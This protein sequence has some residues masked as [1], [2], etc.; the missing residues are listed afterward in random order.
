LL[1]GRTYRI[2]AHVPGEQVVSYRDEDE[3]EEWREE[4][5][6]KRA[7][8]RLIEQGDLEPGDEERIREDFR[9]EVEAAYERVTEESLPDIEE[10]YE[11]VYYEEGPIQ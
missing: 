7:R 11:H 9:Q 3:I 2:P 6:I 5:P 4:D 8:E 1:E 10:V